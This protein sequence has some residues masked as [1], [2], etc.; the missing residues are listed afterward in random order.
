MSI[1]RVRDPSADYTSSHSVY[2]KTGAPPTLLALTDHDNPEQ[3]TNQENKPQPVKR[4]LFQDEPPNVKKQKGNDI[5]L[6]NI[7]TSIYSM[8]YFTIS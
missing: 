1:G 4:S 6:L 3:N 7:N 5:N 2:K 8:K